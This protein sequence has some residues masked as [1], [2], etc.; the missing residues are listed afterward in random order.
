MEDRPRPLCFAGSGTRSGSAVGPRVLLGGL[1]VHSGPHQEP[2]QAGTSR[3]D[4][5][6][7]DAAH[8]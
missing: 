5:V 3:W 2:A 1:R 4:K 7:A 6:V 8:P